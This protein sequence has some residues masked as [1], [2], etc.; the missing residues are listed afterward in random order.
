ML[1][2]RRIVAAVLFTG[3]AACSHGASTTSDNPSISV[4]LRT[5]LAQRCLGLATD[6]TAAV[7][8]KNGSVAIGLPITWSDTAPGDSIVPS[9]LT[10]GDSLHINVAQVTTGTAAGPRTITANVAG[11][12]AATITITGISPCPRHMFTTLVGDSVVSSGTVVTLLATLESDSGYVVENPP[13]SWTILNGGGS[14]ATKLV[15]DRIAADFTVGPTPGP[16]QVEVSSPGL[17]PD[18]VTVRALPTAIPLVAT[19]PITGTTFD[20]D[21]FVRDGIAFVFA[22]DRGV[23]IYDVGNGVRGGSPSNPQLI[24]QVVTSAAGLS[25]GPSVHNGW[26]F[27]NPV[28]GEKRYLFVGQEGPET[29]GKSSSGDIHVVDVSDLTHPVE[30]GFIHIPG[31]GPHNFW[32]DEANQTLYAAY[33]NAGVIKVDVSGTLSGDISNRIVAQVLPGGSSHTFT[34]GVMLSGGTLYAS[35]I[36]SG[37]W[38]L[39]PATL[40]VKG[41]GSNLPPGVSAGSDLWVTGQT[42]YS[43]DLGCGCGARVLVWSLDGNGIPTLANQLTITAGTTLSDVAVSPDG[44]MLVA[45]V[46]G[47]SGNG[48]WIWDR[49]DPVHPVVVASY[50]VSDGLHTG[51]VKV[52][53]GRTYVFAARDP[54]DQALMIFDITDLVH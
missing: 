17:P 18:T 20:H 3:A 12:P 51:E 54:P 22:W 37:F 10:T 24:S 32:M 34:W 52:V 29:V 15:A 35:D 23:L 42:G 36:V 53:N 28:T 19:V 7:T 46:E 16:Q 14:L 49:A 39:D 33:Y 47:G 38:A 30:V 5:D 25:A 4:S 44:K 1:S 21:A 8:D 13:G 50:L 48:L 2:F 41:G 40:A 11:A 31:A 6:V 45:T 27:K 9:S 26:W 43:G